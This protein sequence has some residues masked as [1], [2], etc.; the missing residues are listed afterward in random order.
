VTLQWTANWNMK[1][2][3]YGYSTHQRMLRAALEAQGVVMCDDADIAVHIVVPSGFLPIFA[4]FNILYTMYEGETI[5]DDWIAPL[6]LADLV[7]VPC[8]HNVHVFQKYTDAPVVHCWEGVDTAKFSYVTRAKPRDLKKFRFLWVGASN[9]RKGYEHTAGAWAVFEKEYPK[10]WENC[11]LIF[12]TTQQTKE[13][14]LVPFPAHHVKVETHD[15]TI[16]ELIRLYHSAHAFLFPTMGEGFGLTLAEAM[17]TGL[18]CVYT[19]WSGPNDFI[20]EREGYPLRFNMK[21]T[22]TIKLENDGTRH[23]YHTTT[24]VSVDIK[25]LARRMAQVYADYDEALARGR[26]AAERIRRDITWEKSARSFI[27]IVERYAM[28]SK[29]RA[30]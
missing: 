18:P 4:K 30:A 23:P 22:A 24:S 20:S 9:P 5:P 28:R 19:P 15:Y 6:R 10:E 26:R 2:N 8:T 29:E 27:E 14:R 3:G 7:V 16:D 12:K 17:S 25:H 13:E 11:E 21:E 1:G